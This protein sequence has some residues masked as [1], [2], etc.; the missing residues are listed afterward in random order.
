MTEQTTYED[1]LDKISVELVWITPNAEQMIVDCARVSNPANQGKDGKGLIKYC[2]RNAHW[3]VFE[4]AN[5][6]LSIKAP[7]DISRQILR[8]N[9]A[10][11]Q[12][13]SQRYA[14]PTDDMF[15]LR[16]ARLQDET[17]RQ[18][19]IKTFNGSTIDAWIE[20]QSRVLESARS[21]YTSA[22]AMGIAKEQA[23]AL[24][25]EGLTMSHVY[26]QGSIRTWIHY[27][28][29]RG[30][31]GTQKEHIRVAELARNILVKELPSM[32]EIL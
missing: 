26:M 8:H 29:V 22:R 21:A 5:M 7:R 9:S 30:G 11:F 13:F 4:M 20:L 23:R 18:N 28:S 2:F 19:S 24:L 3:S 25:P 6:T 31:N 27:C 1:A 14:E 16:E 15:C 32:K 17:N 12:E 10:R